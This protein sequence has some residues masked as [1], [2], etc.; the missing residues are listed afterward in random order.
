MRSSP[1]V[2]AFGSA[3][4][5]ARNADPCLRAAQVLY[6]VRTL[7][8]LA[9]LI[10][11]LSSGALSTEFHVPHHGSADSRGFCK[12]LKGCLDS[13]CLGD[14]TAALAIA[15]Q[16]L[17]TPSEFT[18]HDLVVSE[19]QGALPSAPSFAPQTRAPPHSTTA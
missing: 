15:F 8:A 18:A 5:P 6:I 17:G 4:R 19:Y 12:I 7:A 13:K 10:V 1:E 16:D 11:F 3:E 9:C 14:D 2:V